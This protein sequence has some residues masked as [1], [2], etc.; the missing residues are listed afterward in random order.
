LQKWEKRKKK[1]KTRQINEKFFKY[2]LILFFMKILVTFP[3][4]DKFKE[5]GEKY[6]GK[7]IIFYPDYEDADILL[8]LNNNFPYNG[9]VKMIQ[10]ISAGVD[11]IDFSRIGKDTV[12]CSNAG[13]YAI[14]VAEHVFALLL[15]GTKKIIEKNDEM[16]RGIFNS[17]PTT[18]LYGKTLGIIGYGGIGKR[19]ARIAKSFDMN[20]IAIG[21]K[22]KNEFVDHYYNLNNLEFL[23]KNSDFILIS[24]PLNKETFN[25]ID[26]DVLNKIKNG[27]ILINVARPEIIKKDD[28]FD[29]LKRRKDV[30]YLSDVWWDEPE[31]KNTNIENAILTPH[32]AGGKSGE[33]MEIAFKEAYEN[34]LRFINKKELKNLVNRNEYL[35]IDRKNVGV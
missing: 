35:K 15:A 11:H 26:I 34:I 6:F 5:M 32:I 14:S 23:V 1:R 2:L 13:A 31:I 25:L 9:K 24:I 22:D 3:V 33:I 8:I 7:N 16:K 18:L 28:L 21:R 29:F 10:T 4:E 12:V 30:L 20:I 17:T 19:V 27:G